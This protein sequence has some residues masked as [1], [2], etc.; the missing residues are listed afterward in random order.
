M[1]TF[2]DAKINN[3]PKARKIKKRLEELGHQN[4][5][6]WYE[7]VR[8]GC[9]MSGYEGGWFFCSKIID[10]IENIED[11]YFEPIGYSIEEAL[12]YIEEYDIREE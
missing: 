11:T 12:D 9:E 10:E 5:E 3:T 6:V 1:G 2:T 8:R 4:V 7:P